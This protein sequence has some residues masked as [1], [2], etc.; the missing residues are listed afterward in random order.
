MS[1]RQNRLLIVDR[2]EGP[3]RQFSRIGRRLGYGAEIAET[4]EDFVEALE[5]FAPTVILIDLQSVDNGGLDHLKA[6]H[7][8]GSDAQVIL[9]SDRETRALQTAKQ[10]AEFV[11]L[12]VVAS[13][14]SPAIIGIVRHELRRARQPHAEMTAASLKVAL[15][16][17]NVRP[18]YQPKACFRD[19]RDWPI[20]EVEA[21][22]RW[23]LDESDAVMPEDY[24][25][26]AEDAGLLP[27]ITAR[28][29]EQ[30]IAQMEE[31]HKRR[32]KLSVG[33]NLPAAALRD[34]TLPDTLGKRM[35]QAKLDTSSLTLEISEALA[36]S[37]TTTAIEVLNRLKEL[38]FRL[39]IDEFG[40]AFSSLEQLYRLKF[41]ELKIDPSLVLESRISG[42]ARTILEATVAFA[43]KLGISVCAEG[44][45]SQRTLQYLG[46]IGCNK[47]QGNY[48]SRPLCAR[49]LEARL[50]EW[51]V[52]AVAS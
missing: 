11:D 30:V 2:T 41:D 6:L 14:R 27:E 28:L 5:R 21:L 13:L 43:Q 29:L 46:R 48:I 22:P 17:G 20:N 37:Y 39:A 45:D 3:S 38:G 32:I 35:R 34:R 9:T 26:L 52:P 25:A 16:C 50:N 8:D 24:F 23:H 4:L 36:M 49:T 19:R 42:E 1:K 40:T 44:V 7:D 47:A 18:Y 10:F 33:V 51:N 15:E 31:W 12:P